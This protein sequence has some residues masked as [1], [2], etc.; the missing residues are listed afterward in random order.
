MMCILS[1]RNPIVSAALT[2]KRH[3]SS[4]CPSERFYSRCACPP[5]L[6][7]S[8]SSSCFYPKRTPQTP[9]SC[10]NPHDLCTPPVLL[11]PPPVFQSVLSSVAHSAQQEQ[12]TV[13][14]TTIPLAPTSPSP[15]S[16]HNPFS[17]TLQPDD[18]HTYHG[19]AACAVDNKE[20]GRSP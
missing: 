15:S 5:H 1:I 10:H 19:K 16:S 14:D 4:L 8:H 11:P 3:R 9:L 13:F 17:L 7:T 18:I 6:P 2:P 20:R 12:K